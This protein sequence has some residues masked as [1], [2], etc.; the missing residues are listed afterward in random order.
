MCLMNQAQPLFDELCDPF[1]FM[2]TLDGFYVSFLRHPSVF[3][4][5]S[6]FFY[7]DRL[8]LPWPFD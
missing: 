6:D 3:W 8:G 1:S 5:A 4:S 2:A 7:T